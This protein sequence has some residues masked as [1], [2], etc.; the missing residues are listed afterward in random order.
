M[1]WLK[2]RIREYAVWLFLMVSFNLYFLFLLQT[3]PSIYLLYLDLLL[4]VFLAI[5]EGT[6]FFDYRQKEHRKKIFLNEDD[7]IYDTL[8]NP[9]DSEVFQHD[10]MILEKRLQKQFEEIH[11]LQ[12]Y[13]AN[14]CHAFKIPLAAALLI[15]GKIKD[16]DIRTD[17]KEQLERMNWQMSM[18]MQS[19]RLQVPLF[20]LQIKQVPLITCI[21]ASIRNNQ[22]FLIREKFQ[23]D[24]AVDDVT[25]YTDETWL[26]YI[27][28]Q[29][30]NN[31]VKYANTNNNNNT[32]DSRYIRF[33]TEKSSDMIKFFIEDNGEGIQECDIK[34]IFEKGYTGKNYHNGKYKSTGMGLY[35][36]NK[37]AKKLEHSMSVESRY[38]E[39]TRFCILLHGA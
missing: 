10:L 33:W 9:D 39:Y 3:M 1:K 5:I 38:G 11:D 28:D 7:L 14:W 26:T 21:K 8:S 12:D 32:A 35:M 18:V 31:A 27:L 22:F 16:A 13:I 23:L 25:V 24:I 17:M 34:R 2:K 29:L 6:A 4:L 19:C 30:L 37:I 20:D 15:V 36:V